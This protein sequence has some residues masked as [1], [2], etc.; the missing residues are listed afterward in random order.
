[1]DVTSLCSASP[2]WQATESRGGAGGPRGA[3]VPMSS[4]AP[5]GPHTR[6]RA[7]SRC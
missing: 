6:S 2:K 7:H 5:Q 1:M 3:F 4:A